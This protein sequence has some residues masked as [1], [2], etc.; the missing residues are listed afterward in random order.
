MEM[1]ILLK[2]LCMFMNLKGENR[3][4]VE[5]PIKALFYAPAGHGKTVLLG[6][7]AGDPRLSP[8]L[9]LEFEGGTRSIRSKINPIP[10]GNLGKKKPSVDKI[11]TVRIQVWEDFNFGYDYLS[12]DHPYR[13]VGLDSLS[14]MNYLNMSETLVTA[15][16][17]DRQ[18]DPDIAEQ[19]DYLRSYAQM[20]KLV[21]YFRDLPMHVFFT[22]GVQ[23]IQD[24]RTKLPKSW[25]QLTGKLAFE[26][27]GLVEILGYLAVVE[28]G[29]EI[30]RC[31]FTQPTERFEA[32]DRTEGGKLGSAIQDPTLPKILDLIESKEEHQ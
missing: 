1:L 6:T 27:P 16:R 31:L 9:L 12:G 5:D 4:Y 13:S 32:K 11:D 20:R 25:P 29:E 23:S 3:M 2:D 18:H 19:R 17:S 7:A 26:I 10:L 14:E 24:P 28:D 8:M 22:A 15:L 21:R 30:Y